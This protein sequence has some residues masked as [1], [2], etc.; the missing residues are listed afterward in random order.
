MQKKLLAAA[1]LAGLCAV[2]A[3]VS[4][5]Q[6]QPNGERTNQQQGQSSQIQQNTSRPSGLKPSGNSR[7]EDIRRTASGDLT[8]TREQRTRIRD[9]VTQS[10][11]DRQQSVGFTIA[12]GAAVP[13]QAKAR[14][15]PPAVAKAVPSKH[16]LQYVLVRDQLILVD[17]QTRRIVAIVPGMA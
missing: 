7:V 17:K 12:V 6:P 10:H 3:H 9:A 15:L 16:R 5:A 11:L 13:Q 14:D 4:H 2:T 1:A 8:L